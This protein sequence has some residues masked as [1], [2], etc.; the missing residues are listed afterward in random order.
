MGI[1]AGIIGFLVV[2]FLVGYHFLIYKKE[3]SLSYIELR[4]R[5]RRNRI[6]YNRMN[7]QERNSLLGRNLKKSIVWS[8]KRILEISSTVTHV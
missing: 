2:V 6:A 7:E 8:E 4:D 5:L 3:R 1:F